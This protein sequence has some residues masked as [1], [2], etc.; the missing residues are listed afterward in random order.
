[1]PGEELQS[2][3]DE[4]WTRKD[5]FDFV[6][7]DEAIVVSSDEENLQRPPKWRRVEVKW[8]GSCGADVR[9]ERGPGGALRARSNRCQALKCHKSWNEKSGRTWANISHTW[10]WYHMSRDKGSNTEIRAGELHVRKHA[11]NTNNRHRKKLIP[12]NLSVLFLVQNQS[13]LAWKS[14]IL[15]VIQF[16]ISSADCDSTIFDITWYRPP[17]LQP[18]PTDTEKPWQIFWKASRHLMCN[19]FST[20]RPPTEANC[21]TTSTLTLSPS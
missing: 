9:I 6:S 7:Y 12:W 13:T 18:I 19:L 17:I 8:C 14:C 16:N 1:M 2:V 5:T 4:R 15:Q 10:G 21:S 11:P 20:W 3:I